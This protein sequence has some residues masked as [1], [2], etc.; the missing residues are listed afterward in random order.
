MQPHP[1]HGI[2][3]V[4]CLILSAMPTGAARFESIFSVHTERTPYCPPNYNPDP[5]YVGCCWGEYQ[6]IT[7]AKGP[8]GLMSPGCCYE[9]D[10]CTGAPPI[11]YDW[12]TNANDQLVVITPSALRA[13]RQMPETAGK[14]CWEKYK[15]RKGRTNANANAPPVPYL[16]AQPGVYAPAMTLIATAASTAPTL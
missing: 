11:M 8:N 5:D 12:T 2:S 15:C 13:R 4:L 7:S 10:T 14:R 9:Y 1:T 6:T 3:L 16:T